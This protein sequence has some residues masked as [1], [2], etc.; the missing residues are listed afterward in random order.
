MS[1][2]ALVN[3]E[4]VAAIPQAGNKIEVSRV[5]IPKFIFSTKR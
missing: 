4:M 3:G 5:N 1:D 2:F